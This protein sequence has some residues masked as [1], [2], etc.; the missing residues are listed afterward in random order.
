MPPET[1]AKKKSHP[2]HR[3]HIRHSIRLK[4]RVQSDEDL[5][6]WTHNLSL[7]GICFQVDCSF[8]VGETVDL[9]L[10]LRDR[11][12]SKPIHCRCRIVWCEQSEE[13]YR[14]G[15]QFVFFEGAGFRRLKNFL[16]KLPPP[17]GAEKG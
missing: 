8:Q 9:H 6:T 13:G 3:R 7:D 15:G 1:A 16:D 11:K 2:Y 10:Q 5:D 14:H 4:L 17:D 12:P